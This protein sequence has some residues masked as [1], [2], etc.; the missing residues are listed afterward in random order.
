MRR[1]TFK[2]S[3]IYCLDVKDVIGYAQK[4][5]AVS[6]YFR[7]PL[8]S[9][10]VQ[11]TKSFFECDQDGKMILVTKAFCDLNKFTSKWPTKVSRRC[12]NFLSIPYNIFGFQ[13]IHDRKFEGHWKHRRKYFPRNIGLVKFLDL[14]SG[15]HIGLPVYWNFAILPK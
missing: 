7:K 3:A 8:W 11:I 10:F 15:A 13:V 14:V 6:R 12:R 9:D 4:V 2:L 1:M 5:S